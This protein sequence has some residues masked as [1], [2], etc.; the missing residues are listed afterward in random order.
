METPI[1]IVVLRDRT[2]I[3]T[4]E[5]VAMLRL[6]F[7]G[8]SSLAESPSTYLDSAVDLQ[9]RV[10]D[11]PAVP[12]DAALATLLAGSARTVVVIVDSEAEEVVA[13]AEHVRAGVGPD[14]LVLVKLPPVPTDPD[15]QVVDDES[16]I[17]PALLPVVTALRTMECARRS[18]QRDIDP[19]GGVPRFFISHAK[20]EGVPL[21]LSLVGLFRQLRA[22]HAGFDYFYDADHIRAGD[23]WR[24]KIEQAA[25]R[26]LLIVLRTDGYEARDWCRREYL[27]AEANRLPILVIDLRRAS[28]HD[29]SL[30]P[31][32]AAPVVRVHDGN[33]VRIVLHALA[34]HLR[35]LRARHLA[36]SH[37]E[38]LPHKPTVY[39]LASARQELVERGAPVESMVAYPNPPLPAAFEEAVRPLLSTGDDARIAL[40]TYD[41]IESGRP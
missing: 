38:V 41:Q 27:W 1:Q 12:T 28:T 13:A 5:H 19:G 20:Q 35:A 22:A 36:P 26:C 10:L 39:S 23:A 33:I 2:N 18:L 11:P 40:V 37:C 25:K 9:I 32:D 21:A 31:F 8:A 16:A 34:T 15:V 4:D 6:A 7:E 30:L 3:A 14:H 24:Q 29:G 17:E